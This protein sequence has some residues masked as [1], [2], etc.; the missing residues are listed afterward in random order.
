M[1]SPVISLSIAAV[2]AAYVCM[3][4]WRRHRAETA[5]RRAWEREWGS[6]PLDAAHIVAELHALRGDYL[7]AARVRRRVAPSRRGLVA[8]ARQVLEHLSYF[9][10]RTGSLDSEHETHNHLA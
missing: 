1:P 6:Q 2:L 5:R 3:S 8:A 4:V 9:R 10:K 7:A